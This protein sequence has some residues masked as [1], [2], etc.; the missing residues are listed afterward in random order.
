M[1]LAEIDYL[2]E[3]KRNSYF[4]G[5]DEGR[6]EGKLEGILDVAIKLMKK[7]SPLEDIVDVTGIGID[8]LRS[9]RA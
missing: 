1:Y 6:L 8:T 3:E 2:S 4:D 5:K 9:L 7:G